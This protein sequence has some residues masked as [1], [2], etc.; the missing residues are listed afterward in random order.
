MNAEGIINEIEWLEALFSLPDE[1]P[2]LP[3]D[4]KVESAVHDETC[5]H[6]PRFRLWRPEDV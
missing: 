2:L 5:T 6:D 1:R 3:A 4:G